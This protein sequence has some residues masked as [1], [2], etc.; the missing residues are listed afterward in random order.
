MPTHWHIAHYGGAALLSTQMPIV[1]V[2]DKGIPDSLAEDKKLL[3]ISGPTTLWRF[4][5]VPSLSPVEVRKQLL[6][7]NI[8]S[9][10]GRFLK[11]KF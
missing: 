6:R 8:L 10:S 4:S 3:Q 5:N 9:D 2:I 7:M 11:M 1:E